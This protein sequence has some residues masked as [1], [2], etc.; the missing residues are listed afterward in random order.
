M[1]STVLVT[2]A[3]GFL[4]G[5]AIR[6]LLARGDKV[7]ALV[8][9]RNPRACLYTE[10]LAD[11]CVEVRA[12][13]ASVDRV[14]ARYKP[15][16]VL[17]LAAQSQVPEANTD[18]LHTF[19]SNMQ[20][21]WQLLE[22]CRRATQRPD[23][24]LVAS[25]DKAYGDAPLPYHED[26]PL[27]PRHP[28]D[29]SKAAADMLACS[30]REHFGMPVLVTRCANIYGP[31]DLNADRLVPGV[32]MSLARG[33]AVQ[34]RSLG[35]MSREWLH[36]DDAADATLFLMDQL[37][38]LDELV[39][40]VGSGECA[41]VREVV[42]QL[43]LASGRRNPVSLPEQDPEGELAHQRLDTSRL[44]NLGWQPRIALREGLARTWRWYARWSWSPPPAPGAT[45]S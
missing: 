13:L 1:S 2:G 10:D 20:G 34:L 19:E 39:F 31:G 30:Y 25:S 16:K 22:A 15:E 23:A 29:V 38:E 12:D 44:R 43:L 3:C 36:V 17:H 42:D 21:T 28:Y 41:T 7:I 35:S 32:C 33:E 4:G 40:N 18:P 24:V 11:F 5:A 27:F 9:D 14:I 45:A 8:R 37:T 6:A 26:G